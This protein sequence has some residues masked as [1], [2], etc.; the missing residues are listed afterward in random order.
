R[1]QVLS[2]PRLEE[3]INRFNL[4]PELRSRLTPDEIVE[5]MRRSI[6]IKTRGHRAFQIFYEGRDP[7]VVAE[8]AKALTEQFINADIRYREEQTRSTS[9]FFE[10]EL[11]KREQQLR[12]IEAKISEFKQRYMAELPD[13][14]PV[15]LR[16]LDQLQLQLQTNTENLRS[17]EE[18]KLILER[19]LQDL[20]ENAQVV[21]DIRTERD[22]IA[23]ELDA[24]RENLKTLKRTY[25]DKHPDVIRMKKMIAKLEARLAEAEKNPIVGNASKQNDPYR[26]QIAEVEAQLKLAQHRIHELRDNE[27]KIKQKIEEYRKR[28][29][30]APLRDAELTDLQRDYEETKRHYDELLKKKLDAELAAKLEQRQKGEQFELLEQARPPQKPYRPNRPRIV[31]LGFALGF[32]LGAAIALLRD[33]LDTS[34]RTVEDLQLTFEIPVLA[35]IIE[36][37]P[38]EVARVRRRRKWIALVAG[39]VVGLLALVGILTYFDLNPLADRQDLLEFLS[40]LHLGQRRG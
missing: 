27:V 4:Y 14:L 19:Q 28:V 34:F 32:A 35:T 33:L 37:V 26:Q 17:A 23:E 5:V 3:I 6:E 29:E 11:A 18:R 2:R 36:I 15:S 10:D 39:S 38:E 8:V 12:E 1:E 16:L 30:N 20:R 13:N 21:E 40:A 31:L 9:A 22:R 24:A 25:T 7:R